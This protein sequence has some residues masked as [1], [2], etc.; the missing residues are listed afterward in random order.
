LRRSSEAKKRRKQKQKERQR[1]Y[2]RIDDQHQERKRQHPPSIKKQQN[3]RLNRVQHENDDR[4]HLNRVQHENDDRHHLNRVQHE[5][6]D[7]HHLNRAQH[8]TRANSQHYSKKRDRPATGR[9]VQQQSSRF[10]LPKRSA[11]DERDVQ[12][13]KRAAQH[14][15]AK[16]EEAKES[17]R[18]NQ[19][20]KKIKID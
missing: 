10:P 13:F 12:L 8:Q 5:N 18:R 15:Q 11:Y 7:R 1:K 20:A 3:Y 14:Y 4:H 9:N 19:G 2:R 16:Y 6:D 17:L